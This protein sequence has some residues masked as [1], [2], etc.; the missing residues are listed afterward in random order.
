[1]TGSGSG[2]DPS[3]DVSYK[4]EQ[5]LTGEV[6]FIVQCKVDEE[7]WRNTLVR[8]DNFFDIAIW[9]ILYNHFLWTGPQFRIAADSRG[10]EELERRFES[11]PRW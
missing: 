8:F 4:L 3:T 7:P 2:W 11:D 6:E 5:L 9:C 1:M 10:A